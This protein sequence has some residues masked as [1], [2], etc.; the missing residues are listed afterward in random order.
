MT[1]KVVCRLLSPANALLGAAVVQAEIR[2][3]GKLWAPGPLAIQGER[4]GV[5]TVL[6]LHWCDVNVET[7]VPIAVTVT[8]GSRVPI[9]PVASP[10]I[11]VG[12]MAGHLPAVT[13]GSVSIG[14]PV[15][16]LG[17]RG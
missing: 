14:V 4:S 17:A 11:T 8:A 3:D 15:G 1:T 13:V 9:Y 16:A 12:P 10:L 2:G 6:S 7:R 5:A